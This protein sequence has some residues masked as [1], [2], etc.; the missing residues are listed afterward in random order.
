MY[1]FIGF[2]WL[3]L[4]TFV[5]YGWYRR[6]GYLFVFDMNRIAAIIW[7]L[8]IGL[9]DLAL[10]DM[11][12]PSL[13]INAIAGVIVAFFLVASRYS[14]PD[15][16]FLR[17]VV[18]N[19]KP[20]NNIFFWLLIAL[21]AVACLYAFWQNVSNGSLR[22]LSD[23]PSMKVEFED[24]YLYRL[25]VPLAILS[26]YVFRR[27]GTRTGRFVA[28]G[29]FALFLYVTVCDLSRGPLLWIMTGI[30]LL[31][32]FLRAEAKR[33]AKLSGKTS[34]LILVI[35]VFVVWSFDAFGALRTAGVFEASASEY[36]DM[37]VELPTG[38]S[39]IYVYLC[40]PLENARYVIENAAIQ[41]PA[42]SAKLFYP[43]YKLCANLVGQG[44]TFSLWV[45]SR[46][47]V[48]LYLKDSYGLTVG[49]FIPDALQDFWI[50]GVFVYLIAYTC[51]AAFVKKIISSKR[52]NPI[53]KLVVYPL[54]FQG[55]LWSIFDNSVVL[56][57]I[58]V[59][60]GV[61]LIVDLVAFRV[62]G[63]PSHKTGGSSSMEACRLC[64]T[65]EPNRRA[66]SFD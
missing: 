51:V 16:D 3:L 58:W 35:A 55:P 15:V 44:D 38:F 56:G 34:L 9:Y 6:D 66:S 43:I 32:L 10:S 24:G 8:G 42:L 61:F 33:S 36:Y 60:I 26:W 18:K 31:E 23:N 40:S 20:I 64:S 65:S 48:Y 17:E 57:P 62:F 27:G 63:S 4:L 52:F 19:I 54:A 30:L 22:L 12:H 21:V 39:W 59:C 49:S 11:M 53:T 50:P 14:K 37:K 7:L 41:S 1:V 45:A 29:F 25:S 28:L 13:P 46:T 5:S 2:L 47:D